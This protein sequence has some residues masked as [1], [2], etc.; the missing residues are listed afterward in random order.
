VE[1]GPTDTDVPHTELPY[2][3]SFDIIVAFKMKS[4]DSVAYARKENAKVEFSISNAF[5][6]LENS[7][8]LVEFVFENSNY[9]TTSG[10]IRV[11]ARFDNDGNGWKLPAGAS[12]TLSAT[13]WGWK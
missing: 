3:T 12:I 7:T 4:P 1:E 10:W 2:E 5:T 6:Y 11:N 8:D 13:L 9:G